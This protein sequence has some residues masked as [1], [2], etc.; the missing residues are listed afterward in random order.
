MEAF[1]QQLRRVKKEEEQR[2]L[3]KITVEE[4][5]KS[6]EKVK[7]ENEKE[8]NRKGKGQTLE[9]AARRGR[10]VRATARDVKLWRLASSS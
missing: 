1:I 5:F 9:I 8:K 7:V 4:S 10:F 6:E 2:A 3:M